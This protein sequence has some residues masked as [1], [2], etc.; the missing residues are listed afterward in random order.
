MS[1][2]IK[3]ICFETINDEYSYGMY[4]DF[5]VIMHTKSGYIN[6]SYLCKIHNKLY[7]NWFQNDKSKEYIDYVDNNLKRKSTFLIKGGKGEICILI[8]GTYAHPLIVPQ[9][10]QWISIPFAIMVSEIINNHDNIL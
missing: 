7:K 3:H 10:A 6:V 5:K 4:G 1:S 9:V 8:S 2:N